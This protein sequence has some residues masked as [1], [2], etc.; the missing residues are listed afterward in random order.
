MCKKRERVFHRRERDPGAERN[1]VYRRSRRERGR[2]GAWVYKQ[3]ECA[4]I[5]REIISRECK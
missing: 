4:G 2:R 3:T 1:A 5:E